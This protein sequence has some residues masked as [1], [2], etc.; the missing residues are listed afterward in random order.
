MKMHRRLR[1][2]CCSRRKSK[3]TDILTARIN[4]VKRIW[5]SPHRRFEHPVAEGHH[6]AQPAGYRCSMPQ[7]ELSGGC[8]ILRGRCGP[9]PPWQR[10]PPARNIGMDVTAIAPL[11]ITA[12][13]AATQQ[14]AIWRTQQHAIAGHNSQISHKNMRDAVGTVSKLRP[15]PVG[16]LGVQHGLNA[17]AFIVERGIKQ[18]MRAVDPIG[19]LKLGQIERKAWP[20][21]LWRQVVPR[22]SIDV[23]C[24]IAHRIQIKAQELAATVIVRPNH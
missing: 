10:A 19:I 23:G 13:Q 5:I 11:F 15:R 21:T 7:F 3:Y 16:M 17:V 24:V 9:S 6:M 14:Q 22:E 12:S 4:R 2:T 1:F 8:H 20:L 18:N